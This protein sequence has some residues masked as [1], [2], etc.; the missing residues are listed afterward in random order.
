LYAWKANGDSLP[1]FP[2]FMPF[3]A[4]NSYSS[5]VLADLDRD[6]YREII[7][8]TH[9]LGGGGYVFIL[10]RDGT[11]FPN[12]P[13][14][15]GYWIYG[16]PAVGYI[17]ADTLLDIAVGDQVLSGVPADY[18]FAWNSASLP[19]AG[20]PIGP[21]NAI[22]NQVALGDL[23]G[24]PMPELMIDDNTT[25]GVYLAYNHDG[26]PL[27]GWPIYATGTTF[28]NMPCLTDVNRD[29]I[30]DI[31]GAAR[32][33]TASPFTNVYLWN[34]GIAYNRSKLTIPVWQYN[35]AHDGVY[36][37]PSLV[38][39]KE[40]SAEL[41]AEFRLYQNYPNPFNPTT[42]IRFTL[43]PLSPLPV[44]E[45]TGVR[46]SLKIYNLLG[47]EL[48]TLVNEVHPVNGV[49]QPGTY[50]VTWDA[51]GLSSGVY[52]YVLRAGEFTAARKML[53]VK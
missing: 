46:T 52:Y 11:Q 33:G 6:G 20:F 37:R 28:F 24:D 3:N 43:T 53:M 30:L 12:W 42:R 35:V 41:P 23:D 13:Q 44:G 29:G 9:V 1:G 40:E 17:D 16:P 26:T 19:L 14:S 10:K 2:F 7:F 5:P 4:V 21:I 34:T 51:T 39:V 50:E 31:V 36:G 47:R 8:G 22:N 32:E 45:G 18:V 25:A 38:D 15:T 49:K 48:A 27:S